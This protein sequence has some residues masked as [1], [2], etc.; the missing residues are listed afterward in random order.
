MIF[1]DNS[2]KSIYP[3]RSGVIQ[4]WRAIKRAERGCVADQPQQGSNFER[5]EIFPGC[6][7]EYIAP[8]APYTRPLFSHCCDWLSAQSRSVPATLN[9]TLP[10]PGPGI[11]WEV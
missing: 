1:A 11:A 4:N 7:S 2:K 10:N 3:R 5:H 6:T 8:L 9:H